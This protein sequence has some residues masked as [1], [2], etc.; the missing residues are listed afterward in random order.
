MFK[1]IEA[2]GFD[3]DGTFLNTHVDYGRVDRADRDVCLAHGVPFDELEFKTVKRLRAPIREWLVS[4]GREDEFPQISAEIDAKLTAIELENI[5]EAKPF[6][7]SIECVRTLKTNGLKVGLLTRGSHEYSVKALTMFDVLDKFDA[8]VG[9]DYTFYDD[10]KP[11]PKAMYSFAKALGTDASKI[12]YVGDNRTDYYSARDAGARFVGV[13]SG[14]MS[15]EQWLDE[16]PNMITV[17]YAGDI[18]DLL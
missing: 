6:P 7:G 10:A 12:L 15:R 13:L 14:S 2:V 1:G 8:I 16:D 9:R 3:L 17:Q 11:S 5:L 18:L 4:Q